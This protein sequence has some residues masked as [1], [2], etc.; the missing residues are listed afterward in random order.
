VAHRAWCEKAGYGGGDIKRSSF[1]F[2]QHSFADLA[3]LRI[4]VSVLDLIERD[5][6]QQ[7]VGK[8]Q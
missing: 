5:A 6:S 2:R 3:K 7:S 4:R 8:S 1:P